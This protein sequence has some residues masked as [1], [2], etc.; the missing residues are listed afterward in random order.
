M[1][2]QSRSKRSNNRREL[3]A[4][5]RRRELPTTS[6]GTHA[7]PSISDFER[8][9]LIDMRFASE[10]G[11]ILQGIG[12]HLHSNFGQ[13]LPCWTRLSNRV[14]NRGQNPECFHPSFGI[15]LPT[16]R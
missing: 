15:P 16:N 12:H 5:A 1:I 7:S 8:E 9:I 3:P 2:Y 13:A 4:T 11:Q 6:G 10:R 14:R